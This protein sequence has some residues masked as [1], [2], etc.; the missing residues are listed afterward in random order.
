ML[1]TEEWAPKKAEH[2]R[3]TLKNSK[4]SKDLPPAMSAV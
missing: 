4:E 3:G 2:A 1:A